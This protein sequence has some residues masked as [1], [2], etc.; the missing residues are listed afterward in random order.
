MSRTD[1]SSIRLVPYSADLCFEW[2][3]AV[4]AS[5]N[6]T[7]LFDRGF[8]DY[9]ADRFHDASLLFYKGTK[10][11][12]V[13]PASIAEGVVCSHGGL[14]YGGFI[15]VNEVH[16]IDVGRMYDLTLDFYRSKGCNTLIIKPV[17]YIYH[18]TP[19]DED[20]YWIYRHGG[21]LTSRG[22]SSVISLSTPLPFST[23]R[24]RKVKRALRYGVITRKT[25]DISDYQLYWCLL[26]DVLMTQHQRRPVHSLDEIL[27]LRNRFPEQIILHIA[28]DPTTGEVLAGTLLFLT[29]HVVH[30]QYIASSPRGK[31]LGALD[32]VFQRLINEYRQR[33]FLYFDFGIST[34]DDGLYLNEGLNFQKE[35]FGA[36]SVVYD[37]YALPLIH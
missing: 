25:V 20:L 17:P 6:G 4:L 24:G 37:A 34:E 29:K 26:T 8:M 16:A 28:L 36:R 9:H 30:A 11:I 3:A 33:D 31:E 13:F 10:C 32:L 14:T 22:L 21:Q 1:P 15:V 23:L 27:H 7:F 35:G 5:R 18:T 12:G 19:S 2:N